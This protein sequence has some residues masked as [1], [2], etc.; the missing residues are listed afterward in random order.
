MH[1]AICDDNVADRK[2]LER[3]M[4]READKWIA[5]GDAL[6]IF[7]YGSAESI[8]ADQMQ[9]DAIIL[10]I[11]ESDKYTTLSLVDRLRALGKTSVMVIS[12]KEDIDAENREDIDFLPKP[13]SPSL[14]HDVITRV[15][16]RMDTYVKKIELRGQYETLYVMDKEIM[17]ARQM[18]EITRVKLSNG[19][20]IDVSGTAEKMYGFIS[21]SHDMFFM[22]N[23]KGLINLDYMVNS[24]PFSVKMSDG[25]KYS[26]AVTAI[27]ELREKKGERR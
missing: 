11:T 19:R 4:G 15:R 21:V 14:L 24:N 13:V 10:D 25:E 26:L 7:T 9:F 2:Q 22:P 17:H 3:L 12:S 20:S 18:G 8:M 6:Y 23:K 5:N 16:K 1:I 27:G